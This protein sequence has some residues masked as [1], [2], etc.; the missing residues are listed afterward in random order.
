[1]RIAGKLFGCPFFIVPDEKTGEKKFVCEQCGM[2][3]EADRDAFAA[4]QKKSCERIKG[5]KEK[6][7]AEPAPETKAEA[8]KKKSA[9]KKSSKGQES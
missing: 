3:T 6:A 2:T 1:M 4:A 7:K 8:P 5:A 9:A